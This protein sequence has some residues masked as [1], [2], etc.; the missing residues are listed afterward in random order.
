MNITQSANRSLLLVAFI[1]KHKVPDREKLLKLLHSRPGPPFYHE[2]DLSHDEWL[3]EITNHKFV[4]APF[5]HGLDTYRLSEILLMGGIPVTRRSTI[6]SCFDDSDNSFNGTD[7][8]SL[9]IVILDSWA[10]LTKDTL[11]LEWERLSKINNTFWDYKRLFLSQ[12]I[13]RIQKQ[14][15]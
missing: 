4:L 8:G 9:P 1:P 13:N 11:D 14:T 7:R 10:N 2:M 12:W 5:G 15:L 3:A 6:S